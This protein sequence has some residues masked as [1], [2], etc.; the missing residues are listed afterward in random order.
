M[1]GKV[2]VRGGAPGMIRVEI[3]GTDTAVEISSAGTPYDVVHKLQPM[4]QALLDAVP[5]AHTEEKPARH[6]KAPPR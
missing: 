2:L 5:E 1:S 3:E 4:M 6:T